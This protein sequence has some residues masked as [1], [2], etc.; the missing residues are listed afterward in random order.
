MASM[1]QP[2][3]MATTWIG[4][5]VE[6]T[7]LS[8]GRLSSISMPCLHLKR[9]LMLWDMRGSSIHLIFEHGTISCRF[10]KRTRPRLL[11]GAST[12]TTRIVCINGSSYPLG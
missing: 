4:E 2:L 9:S 6:T 10:E 7:V 5:C 1:H 12:L 3:Y 11:F 8:I